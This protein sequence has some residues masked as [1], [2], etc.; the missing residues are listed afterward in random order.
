MII[1][2]ILMLVYLMTGYFVARKYY[3]TGYYEAWQ[4]VLLF[5]TYP[6]IYFVLFIM[7]LPF[8]ICDLVERLKLK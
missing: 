8:H 5:F 4:A 2:V 1:V 3:K 7:S 6:V